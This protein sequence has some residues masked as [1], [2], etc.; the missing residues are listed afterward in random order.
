MNVPERQVS[1]LLSDGSRIIVDGFDSLTN[2]VYEF[3]GDFWHG[4]S[5]KYNSEDI[6]AVTNKTFGELY[7]QTEIKRIKILENNY[8][9]VEIWESE[10]N[11]KSS[12]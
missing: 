5:A 8:N 10:F 4:N 1:I 9:L 6:N 11:K 3:W 2:T 7:K 12:L